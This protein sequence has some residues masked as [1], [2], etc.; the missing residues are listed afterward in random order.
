VYGSDEVNHYMK[1][2]KTN[3]SPAFAVI[4]VGGEVVE[5]ELETLTKTCVTLQQAGLKPIVIHG[6]GP[7]MNKEL[8]LQGVEPQYIKGSRVTDEATL[9]V[10]QRVFTG[11]NKRVVD[12]FKSHGVD[13]LGITTGVFEAK[14][15]NP[16][17]MFVGNITK[18]HTAQVEQALKDNAI[19]VLTSLGQ[20]VDGQVLNINADVA[21]RDMVL[22]M[23]P[24][25][26][27]FAS[28][29]G[30]W[31]DDETKEIVNAIDLTN[32]YDALA[33][34][35]YNG[36]QGTLLKLNEIKAI[37]DG[38]PDSASVAI[39]SAGN[40][41][42]ELFSHK[43]AGT[44]FVKGHPVHQV[45]NSS[46]PMLKAPQVGSKVESTFFYGKTETEARAAAQIV[47]RPNLGKDLP[48]I[49]EQFKLSVDNQGLG[50][51]EI[52]WKSIKAKYPTLAWTWN[53][54]SRETGGVLDVL[55]DNHADGTIYDKQNHK[56][57]SWYNDTHPLQGWSAEKVGRLVNDEPLEKIKPLTFQRSSSF[58]YKVGLLGARGYVGREFTKLLVQHPDMELTVASSR[59]LAGQRVIDCF[60]LSSEAADRGVA[61]SLRFQALEPSDIAHHEVSQNVDIW[62]LALPNGLAPR[63]VPTLENLKE[64][65][66]LIDLGA[67]YRFDDSWVYGLPERHGARRTLKGAR[68]ISNPGCYATG[69]QVGL[70]PLLQPNG[71]IRA[72]DGSIPT[73]FG[74]SGYSGAGTSPSSKNDPQCLKDNLLAY[75]LVDHMHE[76]ECSR[77]LGRQVGFM[78]HVAPYFQG[79]HLTISAHLNQMDV[80]YPSPCQV[81]EYYEAYFAGEPL[82]H[83]LPQGQIPEVKD[84]MFKHGVTVGAFAVDQ[85]TGRI[86]MVSTIDNLLKGAA[87]QAMQNLN[88]ALDVDN[89][90]AGIF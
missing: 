70:M 35:D 64:S 39:S 10:A 80:K 71:P 74:V 60:G 66:V 81:Q 22:A 73:V 44:I 56:Y 55:S 30:G 46:V 78:P 79:I 13:A 36:R 49:L 68:R 19:P 11:L 62:V 57:I 69:T 72:L 76:R 85:K 23:K 61:D 12:S 65:N 75:S 43:G 63:F 31:I 67:D 83:I 25:R 5:E 26:V 87:S 58:K 28:A 84:A 37:L 3:K 7:Q 17:L 4:K 16:E 6:G 9:A 21:A 33:N 20:S 27:L 77:H 29:K 34:L 45:M 90:L 47:T 86:A 52:V 50:T 53:H 15:A 2:F 51:E 54:G 89:E 18:V 41:L 14:I 40:M 38:V 82:I 8:A 48:P 88:I 32:E 1:L 59:A 42:K 24:M